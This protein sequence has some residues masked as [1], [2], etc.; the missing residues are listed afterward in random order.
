MPTPLIVGVGSGLVS[1]A[2]F[3][4]TAASPPIAALLLSLTLL[5]L[6]LAWLGW[7]TA[8]GSMAALTAATFVLAVLGPIPGTSFALAIPMP[9]AILCYLALLSRPLPVPTAQGTAA[10]EWYPPGNLV[11]WAAVIAGSLAA[12]IVLSLGYDAGTYQDGIRN[13]L[14]QGMLKQL[15]PEG[16][17]FNAETIENLSSVLA[18]TLPALFA[19]LW[20]GIMLF[21]I[22]LAGLVVE[23]SGR[24]LRPWPKLDT[25]EL[26][27]TFFILFAGGL[28]LSFVSGLIGLIA[29]GFAGA[30]LFAFVLQ[31]LTVLH[32]WSRGLPFRALLLGAIYLGILLL[33]WVAIAIAIIGLAEPMLRLRERAAYRGRPPNGE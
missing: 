4:S 17:V 30:L 16:T 6:C 9:V 13:L 12:A 14:N 8:A 27:N 24:A 23:A 33:G 1:A 25:L 2:L 26:P 5:P 21:N 15:D 7:G 28:A 32:V 18:R 29:T 3:A 20:F 22:W 11:G 31:G 19:I 10:L